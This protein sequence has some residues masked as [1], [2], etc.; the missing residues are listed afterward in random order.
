MQKKSMITVIKQDEN[1]QMTR[2]GGNIAPPPHGSS[3]GVWMAF[4]PNGNA[5]AKLRKSANSPKRLAKSR[6]NGVYSRQ[7]GALS[8]DG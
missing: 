6:S 7:Q 1:Q 4:A 3:P 5:A 8:A 2:S